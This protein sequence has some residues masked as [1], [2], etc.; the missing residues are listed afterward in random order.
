MKH[1]SFALEGPHAGLEL[2][3]L[4]WGPS[5]AERVVVCVHGLT[6]NAHDFDFLAEFLAQHGVR[7][8]AVDVV[9]RGD[10]SWLKDP[11]GYAV[12][13]YA[14]H[15]SQFLERM[16]LRAVDWIGTSMG[17]FI[18]MVLAAGENTSI[19]RLILND[20]GP[21]IPKQALKQIQTYLALD[22][23]FADLDE[24]EKHLRFIHAP[25]GPLTKRQWQ[26]LALYSVRETG[27][28]LRLNYDPA[29]RK[30]FLE[31]SAEDIEL[32]DLWDNISCPTFL[33]RGMESVLVSAAT[34]AEMQKR[35]PRATVSAV[36]N[37][38]HA[39]ALM[40]RDQIFT[41]ER[42]LELTPAQQTA[43]VPA[44]SGS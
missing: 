26:H 33:L 15:F 38:G 34:A 7:V 35:G 24:V 23:V 20:V 3:Y 4:D 44:G 28:G 41:I 29:I 36:P 39:P 8:L 16:K 9:G 13:V 10:S 6:R 27:D 21:F 14:A 40:S 25:F 37:V 1:K 2:A 43:A 22:L 31:A 32:W 42:W 18:G 11:D 12:P 19:R 5:D 17:G 30:M